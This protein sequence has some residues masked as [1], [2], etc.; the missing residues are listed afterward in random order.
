MGRE[1]G[2]GTARAPG[3]TS[4]AGSRSAHGWTPHTARYGQ[5]GR[6][7][8]RGSSVSATR[9]TAPASGRCGAGSA[10]GTCSASSGR[11]ARSLGPRL[12]DSFA[13]RAGTRLSTTPTTGS[14]GADPGPCTR[15]DQP[16][17]EGD[18][19]EP[20]RVWWSAEDLAAWEAE[21][22]VA[23]TRSPDPSRPPATDQAR[24]LG[25]GPGPERRSL[26]GKSP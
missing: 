19:G 17:S 24:R 1:E 11:P 5:V 4:C 12:G 10:T 21:R 26:H 18:P 20:A 6:R 7:L 2:P 22:A 14:T 23:H 25:A 8:R 3:S 16:L 15:S 13:A 9:T